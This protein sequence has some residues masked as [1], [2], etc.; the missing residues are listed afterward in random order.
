MLLSI[1]NGLRRP[2][3]APC[4]MLATWRD[5]T[6]AGINPEAGMQ[7]PEDDLDTPIWGAGPIAKTINRP[8]RATYHLLE[9]NQLPARKVGPHWVSTRR[10]LRR[11]ILGD[12]PGAA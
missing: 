4:N 12:E 1:S 3:A 7:S 10:R 11:A 6:S 9:T 8:V 2:S 5:A